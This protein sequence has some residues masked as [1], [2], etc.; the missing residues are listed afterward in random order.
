[1]RTF[2]IVAC[3][4]LRRPILSYTNGGTIRPAGN[5]PLISLKECVFDTRQETFK[6]R[7]PNGLITTRIPFKT[8]LTRPG[9]WKP[10]RERPCNHHTDDGDFVGSQIFVCHTPLP[11]SHRSPG[12]SGGHPPG[13]RL[14]YQRYHWRLAVGHGGNDALSSPSARNIDLA[15]LEK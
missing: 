6:G 9:R 15:S 5:R 1:M 4:G 2:L 10:S 11:G 13:T 8:T 3:V 7:F 14:E 12:H